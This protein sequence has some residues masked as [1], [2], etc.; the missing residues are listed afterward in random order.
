[1]RRL[2]HML[3]NG[4]VILILAWSQGTATL[5]AEQTAGSQTVDGATTHSESL[6]ESVQLAAETVKPAI[7]SIDGRGFQTAQSLQP[8]SVAEFLPTESPIFYWDINLK[9]INDMHNGNLVISMDDRYTYGVESILAL[10]NWELFFGYRALTD[11]YGSKTRTD[12]MQ[13]GLRYIWGNILSWRLWQNTMGHYNRRPDAL[14]RPDEPFYLG[15]ALAGSYF[16]AGNLSGQTIQNQLHEHSRVPKVYDQYL[17]NYNALSLAAEL[18]FAYTFD[19]RSLLPTWEM[20]RLEL[21]ASAAA[22]TALGYHETTHL[23]LRSK[24][25]SGNQYLQFDFYLQQ[26]DYYDGFGGSNTVEKMWSDTQTAFWLSFSSRSGLYQRRVDMSLGSLKHLGSE[27]SQSS[28]PF[29]FGSLELSWTM[30][31]EKKDFVQPDYSQSFLMDLVNDSALVLDRF[32]FFFYL[33]DRIPCDFSILAIRD[34]TGDPKLFGGNSLARKAEAAW[35]GILDFRKT[36]DLKWFG[37]LE[38]YAGLGPG[39]ITLQFPK[40]I[41]RLDSRISLQFFTIGG[42]AG[43][44]WYGLQLRRDGTVYGIEASILSLLPFNDMD[45]T[46]RFTETRLRIDTMQPRLYFMLGISILTDW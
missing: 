30:L 43:L 37:F 25:Y 38:L 7:K 36:F 9:Y 28:Y 41:A 16:M 8:Y 46:V 39:L 20:L 15:L 22:E 26:L 21:G 29:G 33:A 19:L 32:A 13:L 23:G 12:E 2:L 10:N 5:P 14:Y 35:L 3:Q 34:I 4:L 42:Q 27:D 24:F 6:P 18:Y 40:S 44:R 11:R 31:Q 1:M 45:S 17:D